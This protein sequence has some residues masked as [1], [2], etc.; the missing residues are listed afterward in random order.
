MPGWGAI[1]SAAEEPLIAWRWFEFLATQEA[2]WR[3]YQGEEGT[4]WD[5]PAEREMSFYGTPAT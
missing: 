5:Y 4:D 2:Q 3:I 1:T